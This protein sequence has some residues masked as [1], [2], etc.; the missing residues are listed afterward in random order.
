MKIQEVL[1]DYDVKHY[2]NQYGSNLV[3]RSFS[4]F[5]K[6]YKEGRVKAGYERSYLIKIIENLD[7]KQQESKNDNKDSKENYSRMIEVAHNFYDI[8]SKKHDFDKEIYVKRYFNMTD[9]QKDQIENDAKRT[10]WYQERNIRAENKTKIQST[11]RD[12]FHAHSS[13]DILRNA[14]NLGGKGFLS[15]A[16][17]KSENLK[18]VF[19]DI[20]AEAIQEAIFC[21]L[22]V[23]RKNRRYEGGVDYDV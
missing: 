16:S 14:F 21:L 13:A 7:K 1:N 18:K 5:E 17:N 11:M 22:Y 2:T 10:I 4:I 19:L 8:V 6:K 20:E 12:E 9:Q 3:N 23:T 15:L